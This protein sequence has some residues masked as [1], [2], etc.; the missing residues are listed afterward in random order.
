MTKVSNAPQSGT[1]DKLACLPN[2]L[3][4]IARECLTIAEETKHKTIRDELRQLADAYMDRAS[5]S[6][7]RIAGLPR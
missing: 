6:E 1:N 5:T 7:I 4:S 3:R 2:M